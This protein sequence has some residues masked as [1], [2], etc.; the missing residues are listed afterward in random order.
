M[1]PSNLNAT[2]VQHDLFQELIY[3]KMKEL[4]AIE[5]KLTK[6][7]KTDKEK[8][9]KLRIEIAILRHKELQSY[10]GNDETILKEIE[11]INWQ[12]E[13]WLE[14]DVTTGVRKANEYWAE[15]FPD[16]SKYPWLKKEI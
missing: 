8:T 5:E 15:L 10:V 2:L 7:G 13:Q 14:K 16:T 3:L 6:E 9:T 11:Y 12:F 4:E 1:K